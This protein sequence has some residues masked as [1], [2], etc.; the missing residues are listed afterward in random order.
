MD[1]LAELVVLIWLIL[2]GLSVLKWILEYLW[3]K[4][5]R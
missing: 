5:E 4:F 1:S 3:N 2:V